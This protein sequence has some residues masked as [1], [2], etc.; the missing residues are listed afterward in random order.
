MPSNVA[1]KEIWCSDQNEHQH[2]QKVGDIIG[3]CWL[4]Q[5][6]EALG[7]ADLSVRMGK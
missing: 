4:R 7:Q 3:F 1:C 2:L 5:S 6:N